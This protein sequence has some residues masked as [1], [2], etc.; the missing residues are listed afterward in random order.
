MLQATSVDCSEPGLAPLPRRSMKP[1]EPQPRALN[2][3]SFLLLSTPRP[4]WSTLVLGQRWCW[5]RVPMFLQWNIGRSAL[6]V[7]P[8]VLTFVAIAR[9]PWPSLIIGAGV[10]FNAQTGLPD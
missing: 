9:D 10:C 8:G 4:P 7:A 6:G 1:A 2:A 5:T 3:S